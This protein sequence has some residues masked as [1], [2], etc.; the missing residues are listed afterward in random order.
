MNRIFIVLLNLFF[1]IK[2]GFIPNIKLLAKKELINYQ[3]ILE[4][5][6]ITCHLQSS[7]I[8][9]FPSAFKKKN[10]FNLKTI[11]E[12]N[13]LLAYRFV[14]FNK[15]DLLKFYQHLFNEKSLVIVNNYINDNNINYNNSMLFRYQN[16]HKEC[17]IFQIECQM[18]TINDYY[19]FIYNENKNLLYFKNINF[20]YRD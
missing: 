17:P 14:F 2:A 20:P 7:R 9:S 6:D 13:D 19:K 3:N 12:V 5:Q 1:S 8:K 4:I 10:K 16:D 15:L 11:Y 18:F